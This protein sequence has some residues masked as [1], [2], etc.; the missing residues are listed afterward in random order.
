MLAINDLPKSKELDSKA[1]V[2]VTGGYYGLSD[3]GA[4]ANVNVNIN[5][6]IAQFQNV[7][8]N[9]LNNI[10]VLGADLGPLH[11]AVS[12]SQWAANHADLNRPGY[13]HSYS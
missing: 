7:E 5:Q 3:I 8:V 10:G 12:P 6:N 9:A 11:F 4:T 13:S 1:M 2:D